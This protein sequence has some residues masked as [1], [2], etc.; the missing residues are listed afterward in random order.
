[1]ADRP[2]IVH[3]T[4]TGRQAWIVRNE[5][6]EPTEHP[7]FAVADATFV[8]DD[9]LAAAQQRRATRANGPR[10]RNL[11]AWVTGTPVEMPPEPHEGAEVI[12]T[13]TGFITCSGRPVHRA[14]L[15]L[16]LPGR[17]LVAVDP[18]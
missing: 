14:D 15:A 9:G 7:T 12:Y 13:P 10:G 1:M 18:T 8:F 2:V 17:R 16:F 6:R 11:H 4:L 3:A 5:R